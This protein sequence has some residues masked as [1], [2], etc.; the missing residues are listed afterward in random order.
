MLRRLLVP[1]VTALCLAPAAL[2]SGPT[3]FAQ[4]GGPGVLSPDGSLRY[5]ALGAGANT[6]LAQ[7]Q[8]KDGAAALLLQRRRRAEEVVQEPVDARRLAQREVVV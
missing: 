5:L 4:Q 6:V 2:A 1:A 3:P 8:T 7:V